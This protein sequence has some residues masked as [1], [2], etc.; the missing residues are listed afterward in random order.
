VHAKYRVD[1]IE[2]TVPWH[3]SRREKGVNEMQSNRR[4]EICSIEKGDKRLRTYLIPSTGNIRFE[5]KDHEKIL[6]NGDSF[7]Q[8]MNLYEQ[9]CGH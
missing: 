5:V 2:S 9:A 3:Y 1:L 4:S 6:Y 8:A 7:Q